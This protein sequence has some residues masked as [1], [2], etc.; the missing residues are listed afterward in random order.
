M[1]EHPG[2]RLS[3]PRLR[4]AGLQLLAVLAL[5]AGIV[6]MHSLTPCD[7]DLSA[8][9]AHVATA[10]HG[11]AGTLVDASGNDC[12]FH[13]CSAIASAAPTFPAPHGAGWAAPLPIPPAAVAASWMLPERRLGP[14]PPWTA[15]TLEQLSI[16]RV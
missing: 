13:Q 6:G 7:T 9:T 15:Y 5:L 12:Q 16:L 11:H 2:S 3:T 14:A 1:R 8:T 4:T 10:D